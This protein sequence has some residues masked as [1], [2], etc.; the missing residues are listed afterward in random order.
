MTLGAVVSA[1]VSQQEGWEFKIPVLAL[2]DSVQR[3]QKLYM[4]IIQFSM[5]SLL[6][7]GVVFL[8]ASLR[9]NQKVNRRVNE[10]LIWWFSRF[11]GLE[12]LQTLMGFSLSCGPFTKFHQIWFRGNFLINPGNK[13][14][15]T[16]ENKNR[17]GN[18]VLLLFWCCLTWN[19]W[20]RFFPKLIFLNCKEQL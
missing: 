19:I 8:P 20:I 14:R 5:L 11:L 12:Q 18:E 17:C 6:Q 10:K 13:P 9:I 15:D 1:V 7:K 16:E 4:N 3:I 2:G